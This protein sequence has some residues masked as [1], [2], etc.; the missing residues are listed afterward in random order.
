V[1][2][3]VVL[4]SDWLLPAPVVLNVVLGWDVLVVVVLCF[5]PMLVVAA[6]LGVVCHQAVGLASS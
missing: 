2:V 3:A 4:C 5:V 1:L 6:V